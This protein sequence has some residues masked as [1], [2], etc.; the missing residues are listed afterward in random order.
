MNHFSSP[1][2]TVTQYGDLETSTILSRPPAKQSSR[3]RRDLS[4]WDRLSDDYILEQ[5]VFR[6]KKREGIAMKAS[7]KSIRPSCFMNQ[8]TPKI[9]VPIFV[10]KFC[11]WC[12]LQVV[13]TNIT[14][15]YVISVRGG[16]KNSDWQF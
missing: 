9:E 10:L 15:E 14:G 6:R 4:S 16:V 12:T 7:Q 11:V 2:I 3:V 13:A 5:M 1:K 8:P